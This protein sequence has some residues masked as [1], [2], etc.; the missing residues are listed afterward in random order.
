VQQKTTEP[1]IAGVAKKMKEH[2]TSDKMP[3]K[4]EKSQSNRRKPED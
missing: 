1:K 3:D 2:K 4:D